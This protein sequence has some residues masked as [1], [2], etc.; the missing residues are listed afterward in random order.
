MNRVSTIFI[1]LSLLVIPTHTAFG[2]SVSPW[3]RDAI[4]LVNE[5]RVERG[6]PALAES[7]A[8][9]RSAALKLSD[10][11]TGKYFAHTS[12][13]GATPWD[14][15]D[16]AGYGY[17]YAGE[18]LAIHFNTPDEEHAAWMES[19]K[20]CQNILD[21]R[22]REIGM[23]A[24]KV[25][26]EGRETILVVQHFGTLRGEETVAESDK[27]TAIALCRGETAERVYGVSG[28]G[29]SGVGPGRIA[30]LSSHFRTVCDGFSGL[31][32]SLGDRYGT[33]GLPLVILL[34]LVQ[35]AAVSVSVR[36]LLSERYREGIYPS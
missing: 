13:S 36:I 19:E 17:R 4:V 15:F 8:L 16:E 23:S 9:S 24:R 6:L 34:S 25:F 27:Q 33:P 26:L 21:P 14:F 29:E 10:M 2:E 5:E 20:H 1:T 18:N 31:A 35:L 7:E 32:R 30:L 11:E 22:F 12:P 3:I 28:E